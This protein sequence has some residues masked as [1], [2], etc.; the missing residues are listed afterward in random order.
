MTLA[1]SSPVKV[2]S[3]D[4]EENEQPDIMTAAVKINGRYF[5]KTIPEDVPY[6]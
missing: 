4:S 3:K 5:F 2:G 6:R 1:G